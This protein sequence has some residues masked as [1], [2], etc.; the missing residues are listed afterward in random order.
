MPYYTYQCLNVACNEEFVLH[1]TLDE[2]DRTHF[3]CPYCGRETARI[4]SRTSFTIKG[5][6]EKNGYSK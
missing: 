2:L 3:A 1:L 4:P 6:S 5:F